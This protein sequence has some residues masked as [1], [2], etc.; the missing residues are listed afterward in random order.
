MIK[1]QEFRKKEKINLT[2]E[3]VQGRENCTGTE[4][5][6][7]KRGGRKQAKKKQIA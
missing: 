6:G 3:D 5:L 7:I 2:E 1:L 4:T